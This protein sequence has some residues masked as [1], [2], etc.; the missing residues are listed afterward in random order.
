MKVL[1]FSDYVCPLCRNELMTRAFA[2]FTHVVEIPS[3]GVAEEGIRKICCM[4]ADCTNYGKWVIANPET[5]IL[6]ETE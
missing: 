3:G 4:V 2:E 6:E 5:I 1:K